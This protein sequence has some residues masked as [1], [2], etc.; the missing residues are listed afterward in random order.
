MP[1]MSPLAD[2]LGVNQQVAVSAFASSGDGLSNMLWVTCGTLMIGLGIAKIN[3]LSWVK[4][5]VK[6]FLIMIAIAVLATMFAQGY[7][8]EP[9]L[10]EGY[11]NGKKYFESVIGK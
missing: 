6:I 10:M 3:Y 9:I 2:V 8:L 11:S 1:I 4:F 5:I 7:Q